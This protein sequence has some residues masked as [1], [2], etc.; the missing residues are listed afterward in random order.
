VFLTNQWGIQASAPDKPLNA[1][2]GA[3]RRV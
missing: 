1:V 3:L 2:Y